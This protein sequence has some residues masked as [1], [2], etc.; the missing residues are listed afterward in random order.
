MWD[1]IDFMLLTFLFACISMGVAGLLSNSTCVKRKKLLIL[2]MN[3]L[4]VARV[5]SHTLET[6][7]PQAI[8]YIPTADLL[9]THY[10]WKRPDLDMFLDYCFENFNVAVWTSARKHNADKLCEYVFGPKRR[11][12]LLWEFNQEHCTYIKDDDVFEKNLSTVWDQFKRYSAKNTLILDD[13]NDKM[14]N[15]PEECVGVCDSWAPWFNDQ[16]ETLQTVIDWLEKRK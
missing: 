13:S 2:D 4:L 5:Y 3:N 12:M 15:N 7:H 16:V 10:T 1:D 14:R 8:D 6:E 9:G 11:H